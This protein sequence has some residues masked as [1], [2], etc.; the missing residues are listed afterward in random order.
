MTDLMADVPLLRQPAHADAWR[1]VRSPGGY[2]WWYFD[3]EDAASDV[4]VVG[5]LLDGFV[6]HPEYLRRYGNYVRR[7]TRAAPPQA[8]EYPCAYFVVY[9]GGKIAAQF[10]TQFAAGSLRASG[11]RP[12]VELGPNRM[13]VDGGAYQLELSGAPWKLTGQ[14]PKVIQGATLTASLRYAPITAHRPEERTFLSRAMTGA[15]HGWVL[16]QPHSRVTGE[17]RLSGPAGKTWKIAGRG[18]HDHNFGTAPLGPGLKRWFWGR[19]VMEDAAYVF[20]L[21]TPEDS[22]LALESHFLRVGGAEGVVELGAN[23]TGRMPVLRGSRRSSWGL[24]YPEGVEIG[25]LVS[26]TNPRVVD[27]EPFYLR[28]MYDAV[29]EGKSGQAF[30]EVAYPHRLRWPVLGRMIGMSISRG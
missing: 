26:L 18:Y 4:Q 20:H 29:C 28:V 8:R 30:C 14:G 13:R 2:E 16:A 25:E 3:A 1:D 7:P 6:F 24:A 9:E 27:S 11:E 10:M 12:E 21:A 5:I 19:V 22:S 23:R 17:V 15:E